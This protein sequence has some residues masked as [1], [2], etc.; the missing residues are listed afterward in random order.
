MK[1]IIVSL[2]LLFNIQALCA[3][4]CKPF[5]QIKGNTLKTGPLDSRIE[6]CKGDVININYNGVA[7]RSLK[8]TKE[9]WNKRLLVIDAILKNAKNVEPKFEGGCHSLS[10]QIQNKLFRFCERDEAIDLIL[11]ANSIIREIHFKY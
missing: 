1:K 10:M 2:L 8:V 9:F 5:L 6:K 11:H 7:K 4:E 3:K